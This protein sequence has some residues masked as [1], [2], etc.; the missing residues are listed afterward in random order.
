MSDGE[1][2]IAEPRDLA[3]G[4]LR[5]VWFKL[6]RAILL[7]VLAPFFPLRIEG[8]EHVPRTGP[9][10]L[11]ANHLHNA[12]PILLSIAFPRPV[13]FMAKKEL[14]ST[15][16]VKWIIRRVG[17]FPVDRGR[18]DR[19]AI[20]HAEAALDQ[21]IAVG[22]FPEGTRSLGGKLATAHPG[23][24][25]LA[26]RSGALVVPVAILGFERLPLDGGKQSGS[27]V[28]TSSLQWR[29]PIQIRIGEPF[30]VAREADGRRVSAADATVVMMGHVAKLLPPSYRGAYAAAVMTDDQ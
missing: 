10:L 25:M 14:F 1:R 19:G 17:A 15:P 27:P 2:A 3:Q 18:S 30:V 16:V 26:Q 28:R 6:V 21:G 20:R 4:T 9:M 8:L 29:K 7:N 11:V 5:G 24:A 23:A 12:D 13:H 22:M